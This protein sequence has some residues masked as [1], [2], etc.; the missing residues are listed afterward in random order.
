ML[1]DPARH[2]PLRPLAWDESQ[3]RAEARFPTLDVFHG[4]ETPAGAAS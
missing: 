1:Y 2:E 3:V 4:S